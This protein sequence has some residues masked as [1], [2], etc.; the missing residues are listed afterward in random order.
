MNKMLKSI[1][2]LMLIILFSCG[3]TEN[4]VDN[5]KT[6]NDSDSVKISATQHI[7]TKEMADTLIVKYLGYDPDTLSKESISNGCCSLLEFLT[8]SPEILLAKDSLFFVIDDFGIEDYCP[9]NKDDLKDF[10]NIKIIN[11][12]LIYFQKD[13]WVYSTTTI[14]NNL[15]QYIMT[16]DATTGKIEALNAPRDRI[17]EEVENFATENVIKLWNLN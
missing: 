2:L 7:I 12:S 9:Y 10:E 13:S 11:D 15:E 5:Q 1:S 6:T 4:P 3:S 17:S 14:D 16:V 8:R